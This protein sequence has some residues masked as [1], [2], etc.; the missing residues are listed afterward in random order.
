M[1]IKNCFSCC[2]AL[3]AIPLIC[4]NGF[5]ASAPRRIEDR[6][7]YDPYKA[8]ELEKARIALRKYI[9]SENADVKKEERTPFEVECCL[10]A[11]G[12]TTIMPCFALEKQHNG[13]GKVPEEIFTLAKVA[14][15][16]IDLA[17][18][19]AEK[20]GASLVNERPRIPTMVEYSKRRKKELL[21]LEIVTRREQEQEDKAKELIK[22]NSE[23]IKNAVIM[24]A[25]LRPSA[26]I[27]EKEKPKIET[28][29]GRNLAIA[30]LLV[31]YYRALTTLDAAGLDAVLCKGDGM[32]NGMDLVKFCKEQ[33][34][35]LA[36][37]KIYDT[38]GVVKFD[39]DTILKITPLDNKEFNVDCDNNIRTGTLAG[40]EVRHR[41]LDNFIVRL[42]NG[43]YKI[44]RDKR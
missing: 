14:R 6:D 17:L 40:K 22:E 28:I 23:Y 19:M 9:L 7:I 18:K 2:L 10:S 38:I 39:D 20:G 1:T 41:K 21:I 15:E 32:M 25:Q 4:L 34:A 12:A 37:K 26:K 44:I 13:T 33:L 31:D 5:C 8:G 27:E 16:S 3:A 29:S 24:D 43:E 11:C 36:E 35:E 30:K 42:V